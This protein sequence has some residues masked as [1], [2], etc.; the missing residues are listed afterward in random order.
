[1]KIRENEALILKLLKEAGGRLLL[2]DVVKISKLTHAAAMR[3]AMSLELKNLIKISEKQSSIAKLTDEG[4][5]YAESKLPERLLIESLQSLGGEAYIEDVLRQA[6]L[7]K[8]MHVISLG[9]AIRKGWVKAEPQGGKIQ[10]I[11]EPAE[12]EDEKLLSLLNKRGTINI[13]DLDPQLQEALKV[14]KRRNLVIVRVEKLIDLELTKKG[15]EEIERGIEV[16]REVSQLTPEI[17]VSGKWRELALKEY[18]IRAPV[19]RTWPGKKHPYLR[20]L[21][22]LKEKLVALG[23]KEMTGPIVEM[24]FFNCDALY[25][26]Q[27]HPAREVHDMYFIKDPE[28]GDLSRYRRFLENVRETHEG[29]W[30]TGSK[31]WNYPFSASEAARLMLRSQTTSLSAR[32]LMSEDLE[33]PGKYFAIARCYR[34]DVIDRTHLTEFN[35]VEGIVVGEGLTLRDLL[36]I[37]EKFA[38]D[39]AGADKVKY[40]PDYFPFT[41]PSVELIA[42]KEGYGWMEFGGSG[43]FRPEVTLPLGVE[44]PVLAWG[45]GVDRLFMMKAGVDDIRYLFTHKLD[46]LREMRVV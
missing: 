26:P 9:W 21:D 40:R 8:E 1:M 38:K 25:M 31:G 12:G 16:L 37:L 36:G 18:D 11:G 2:N 33:I 22:E 20:F 19:A 44:V 41:E 13:E 24:S 29:G 34:P 28:Y 32:T 7:R 15:L 43:I 10:L 42:Y 6:N 35:Q 46:W 45:L 14:L 27:D 4:R 3:A 17:I 23:F 30:K 39:V 5:S